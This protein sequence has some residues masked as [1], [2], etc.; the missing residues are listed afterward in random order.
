MLKKLIPIFIIVLVAAGFG[1]VLYDQI[2]AGPG[3]LTN[4]LK[5]EHVESGFWDRE[6]V[7]AECDIGNDNQFCFKDT[8]WAEQQNEIEFDGYLVVKYTSMADAIEEISIGTIKLENLTPGKLIIKDTEPSEIFIEP[9]ASAQVRYDFAFD[10]SDD[11][12]ESTRGNGIELQ[13]T[14]TNAVGK[15]AYQVFTVEYR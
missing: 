4:D 2:F 3:E 11:D 8:I 6:K 7:V 5:F 9:G 1:W 12:H 15:K 13:S 14:F 10:V